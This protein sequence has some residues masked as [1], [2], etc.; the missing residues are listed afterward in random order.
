MYIRD[1]MNTRLVT[2]SSDAFLDDAEKLMRNNKIRRLPVV[3]HGKLVGLVTRNKIRDAMVSP[4][5]SLTIREFHFM[6]CKMQV[7]NVMEKSLVT[8]DDDMT[9]EEALQK[10]QER[11]VGT[12]LVV[13]KKKPAKLV[14]IAV[15]RDIYNIT[16]SILGFGQK[17]TRLHIFEPDKTGGTGNLLNTITSHGGKVR[18][19]FHVKTP[20]TKREDCILHLDTEDASEIVE[21]LKEKGYQ[22]EVRKL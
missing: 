14:G 17:G 19:L 6:V 3:D 15:A 20:G 22:L 13:D 10:A 8:I 12:L 2:V 1:Y 7:K 5:G 16:T 9:V 21:E 11:R 18:S 4:S